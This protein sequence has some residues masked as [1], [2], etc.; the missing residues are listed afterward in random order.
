MTQDESK[1]E[2]LRRVEQGTLS[3]E[4]G[5]HLLEILEGRFQSTAATANAVAEAESKDGV[6]VT[7]QPSGAGESLTVPALWKAVWGIF[8]WLGVAFLGLSGYWLYSSYNR[9]GL[10]VGF[11][12]ALFFVLVSCLIVFLGWQIIDSRWIAVRIRS[13]GDADEKKFTLWAPLPIQF[14]RWIF[15]TFGSYMPEKVQAANVVEVLNEMER[16]TG[17]E[18]AFVVDIE[19]EEGEQANIHFDNQKGMQAKINIEL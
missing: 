13:H 9:S 14:A 3:I 12:F 11:W 15:S 17:A 19:G 6:N 7:V 18:D 10:G 8:L 5:A 4:E 2:I 1:L 16:S